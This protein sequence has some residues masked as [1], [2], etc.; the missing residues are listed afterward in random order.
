MGTP[1]TRRVWRRDSAS[2]GACT[3]ASQKVPDGP[4]QPDPSTATKAAVVIASVFRRGSALIRHAAL[5]PIR[6][7][8]VTV[9]LNKV[10]RVTTINRAV[11]GERRGLMGTVLLKCTPRTARST[12]VCGVEEERCQQQLLASR[13]IYDRL[14]GLYQT[15]GMDPHSLRISASVR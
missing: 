10:H 13:E 6:S 12:W 3:A 7:N 8:C 1:S 11:E 2:I 4:G 15:M 9:Q 5:S 14:S